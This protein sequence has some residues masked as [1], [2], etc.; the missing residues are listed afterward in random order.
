M[1]GVNYFGNQEE[2]VAVENLTHGY[3]SLSQDFEGIRVQVERYVQ[4]HGDDLRPAVQLL[5]VG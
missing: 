4:I 5:G 2:Q 3:L 1:V